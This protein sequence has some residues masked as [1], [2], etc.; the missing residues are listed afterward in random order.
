MKNLALLLL[1]AVGATVAFGVHTEYVPSVITRV[2]EQEV[3]VPVTNGWIVA[4]D[5]YGVE[6]NRFPVIHFETRRVPRL[7][8]ITN[9]IP[10]IMED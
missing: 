9:Q 10:I 2:I 5:D 8:C 7:V 6:T 3:R 4:Y 1:I